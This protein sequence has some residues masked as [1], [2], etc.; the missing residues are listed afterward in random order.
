MRWVGRGRGSPFIPSKRSIER[1]LRA[2]V[3][4]CSLKGSMFGDSPEVLVFSQSNQAL[5]SKIIVAR[6]AQGMKVS[7]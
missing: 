4:I 3:L 6:T 7:D 2:Q 1:Q 5:I